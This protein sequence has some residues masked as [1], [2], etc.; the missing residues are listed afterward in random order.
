MFI[1]LLI[2]AICFFA[3]IY[4]VQVILHIIGIA[5]IAKRVGTFD[6][7]LLIPFFYYFNQKNKRK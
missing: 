3:A 7:K 2:V 6:A 1:R 4:Y 5:P